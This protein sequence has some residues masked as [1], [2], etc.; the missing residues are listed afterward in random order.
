MVKKTTTLKCSK[1]WDD[2]YKGDQLEPIYEPLWQRLQLFLEKVPVKTILDFGCGD[3]NYSFL[4]GNNGFDV[5][6]IDIS[7]NAIKKATL[8]K[9]S[10]KDE[11]CDFVC[12]NLI[13]D[14]LPNDSFDAVVMLNSYHCLNDKERS[15]IIVQINRVLKKGGYF[16]ASVLAL[17]DESYPR[18]NWEEI[19]DSTFDD[20][21]GKIFHFFSSEGLSSELKGLEILDNSMLQAI[22]PDMGRKSALFVITAKRM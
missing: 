7:T 12:H 16:F 17:E 10:C 1:V 4:L 14:D 11:K 20:G 13:P 6:G 3:G 22:H 2:K 18:N 5:F 15:T 19:E 21:E 8:H 9:E